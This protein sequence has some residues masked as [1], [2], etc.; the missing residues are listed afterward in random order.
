MFR[1]PKYLKG[2]TLIEFAVSLL[3]IGLLAAPL[4]AY[5]THYE[6]QRKVEN[7]DRN[8]NSVL[9]ALELYRSANGRYPCPAPMNAGRADASYGVAHEKAC[10][11]QTKNDDSA[12]ATG[13]C[14]EGICILSGSRQVDVDMDKDLEDVEVVFGAVP[15]RELQIEEE[16]SLDGHGSKLVYAVTR[17]F[18]NPDATLFSESAGGIDIRSA[19]SSESIFSAEQGLALFAVY[20]LG[21]NKEGAYNAEG[22]VQRPCPADDE[23]AADE[24]D[25]CLSKYAGGEEDRPAILTT[26]LLDKTEDNIEFDDKLLFTAN[27]FEN[28]WNRSTFSADD[29]YDLNTQAVGVGGTIPEDLEDGMFVA[30]DDTTESLRVY[31][32]NVTDGS[33]FTDQICDSSDN[34]SN[35]ISTALLTADQN[36]ADDPGKAGAERIECTDPEKP[37]LAGLRDADTNT[38]G[39]QPDCRAVIDVRCPADKPVLNAVQADGTIT[40]RMLPKLACGNKTF[41]IVETED[42]KPFD[43]TCGVDAYVTAIN[44]E[45]PLDKYATASNGAGLNFG[46]GREIFLPN[47]TTP[48]KPVYNNTDGKVYAEKITDGSPTFKDTSCQINL[49]YTCT[50]GP[51]NNGWTFKAREYGN[52]G[53]GSRSQCLPQWSKITKDCV[54]GGG[55][56]KYETWY[57]KVCNNDAGKSNSKGW[58]YYEEPGKGKSSCDC[59]AS[60]GT[61]SETRNCS[62]LEGYEDSTTQQTRQVTTKADCT[63]TATDWTPACTCTPRTETKT[64]SCGDGSTGQKTQKRHLGADCKWTEDPWDTSECECDAT[65]KPEYSEASCTNYNPPACYIPDPN[66]KATIYYNYQGTPPNCVKTYLNDYEGNTDGKCIPKD[67][68]W[69]EIKVNPGSG[70]TN[71][72]PDAIYINSP[73]G[74]HDFGAQ[75]TCYAPGN[76]ADSF[77]C[78][79]E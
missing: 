30:T 8:L 6:Q 9:S 10:Q 33:I 72:P 24:G 51:D 78:R 48:F 11:F 31:G 79:C 16:E 42:G 49:I 32:S 55:G 71:P 17:P 67:T 39:F 60:A 21:P 74:C 40:C 20:S 38:P 13:D 62:T 18:A 27:R 29:I 63:Q 22:I 14:A 46:G 36:T 26:G 37:Y 43:N 76:F 66:H 70:S 75:K 68:R 45:M 53:E 65:P 25:N 52:T 64:E 5:Y 4:F 77:T 47:S 54:T 3:V 34:A 61:K 23:N 69:V 19:Q 2:F 15:F 58:I 7:S 56:P 41:K 1:R 73:C 57:I 50:G 12:I 59:S 35:C 28:F 44:T